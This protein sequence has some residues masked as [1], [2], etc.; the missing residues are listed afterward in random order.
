METNEDN[1]EAKRITLKSK[2]RSWHNLEFNGIRNRIYYILD[3]DHDMVDARH[4]GK[5]LMTP[6]SHG[7][8]ES[9]SI[10][11]HKSV[12]RKFRHI[13]MHHELIEAR[14]RIEQ[15][16][17]MNESHNKAVIETHEYAKKHLSAEDYQKF[18]EWEKT[19]DL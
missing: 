17:T 15:N 3:Q 8:G 2:E 7:G 13:V 9:L 4:P 1:A 16:L 18:L 14:Y 5:Y 10:W 19:L 11:I 6:D 12:P